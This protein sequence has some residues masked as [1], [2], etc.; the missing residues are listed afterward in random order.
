MSGKN[1][2]HE[3]HRVLNETG[4]V[5]QTDFQICTCRYCSIWT[6]DVLA[7]YAEAILYENDIENT[8]SASKKRKLD[9]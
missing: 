5:D 9:E 6:P 7:S 8:K 1:R 4:E 2:I 3:F